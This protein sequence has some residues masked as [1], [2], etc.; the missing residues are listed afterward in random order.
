M[1]SISKSFTIL[2]KLNIVDLISCQVGTDCNL[3]LQ[4]AGVGTKCA[5]QYMLGFVPSE[6]CSVCAGV[7]TQRALFQIRTFKR[8]SKNHN[9]LSVRI[10][11]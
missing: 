10:S 6:L 7:G 11:V 3:L 5:A 4:Y 1:E 8:K 9:I 2:F